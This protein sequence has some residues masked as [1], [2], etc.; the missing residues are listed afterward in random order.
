MLLVVRL[1]QLIAANLFDVVPV[2]DCAYELIVEYPDGGWYGVAL[3]A[4]AIV[5]KFVSDMRD[6]FGSRG[7]RESA[8]SSLGLQVG[9]VGHEQPLLE[10]DLTAR[11][12]L[13]PW[14]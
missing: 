9:H 5:N 12:I 1:N 11:Q 10:Q 8:R 4:G 3:Q 6:D 14:L 2:V 7:R 13:I